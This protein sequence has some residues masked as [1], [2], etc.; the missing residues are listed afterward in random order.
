[1]RVCTIIEDEKS[2]STLHSPAIKWFLKVCIDLSELF[3]L[4]LLGGTNCYLMFM[5][6]IFM[7]KVVDTSLYMK[8]EPG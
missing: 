4:W 1:M 3:T 8:W 2:L 7:F 6:V 5:V